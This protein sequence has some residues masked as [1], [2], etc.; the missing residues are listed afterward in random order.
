MKLAQDSEKQGIECKTNSSLPAAKNC[1][2]VVF[3][4]SKP[5]VYKFSYEAT[6]NAA[7][8][9]NEMQTETFVVNVTCGAED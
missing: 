1:S 7:V 9:F 3:D 4:T 6:S 2:E 8:K 5:K